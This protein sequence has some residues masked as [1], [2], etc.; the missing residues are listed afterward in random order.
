MNYMNYKYTKKTMGLQNPTTVLYVVIV[1]TY[2][3]S[4]SGNAVFVAHALLLRGAL[5]SLWRQGQ[6]AL[7]D[8]QDV[9]NTQGLSKEV[10]VVAV[11][12]PFLQ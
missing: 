2:S 4:H 9:V 5:N 10:W 1:N 3:F 12:W 7:K 6:K 8:L 11:Q